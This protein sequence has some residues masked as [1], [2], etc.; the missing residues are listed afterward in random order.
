MTSINFV[1]SR[2]EA[3]GPEH[4]CVGAIR[5][6]LTSSWYLQ[7]GRKQIRVIPDCECLRRLM[8]LPVA[9]FLLTRKAAS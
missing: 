8:A 1:V 7:T 3:N 9:S 5:V 4:D 6:P 2:A